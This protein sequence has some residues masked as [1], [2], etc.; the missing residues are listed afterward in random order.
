MQRLEV[1]CAIGRIYT[2]LG[3]KGLT[4]FED[5]VIYHRIR[6]NQRKNTD[7]LHLKV[8]LRYRI[9]RLIHISYKTFFVSEQGNL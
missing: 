1:S 2:S 4:H 5:N 6:D 9:E 8:G 7:K 3:A